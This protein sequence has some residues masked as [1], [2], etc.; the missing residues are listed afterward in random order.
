[1]HS[2]INQEYAKAAL[3]ARRPTGH[4]HRPPQPQPPPGRLRAAGARTLAT[5][6]GRLDREAARRAVA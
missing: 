1:M 6:A 5:L 3:A 4:G 2:I